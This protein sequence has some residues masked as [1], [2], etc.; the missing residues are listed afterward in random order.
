MKSNRRSR[1]TKNE[2]EIIYVTARIYE[3]WDDSERQL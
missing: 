2:N 3:K 1:S